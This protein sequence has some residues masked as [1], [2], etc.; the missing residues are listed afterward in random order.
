MW[1][2][3]PCKRVGFYAYK[4]W[5]TNLELRINFF[6]DVTLLMGVWF[7]FFKTVGNTQTTAFHSRKPE[8]SATL[9]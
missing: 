9:Q 7:P 8:F 1:L 4:L 5:Y 6:W 3:G 2:S